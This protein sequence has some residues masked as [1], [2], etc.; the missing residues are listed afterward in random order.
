LWGGAGRP[1]FYVRAI[2]LCPGGAPRSQTELA[3]AQGRPLRRIV[4]IVAIVLAL[5]VVY[6]VGHITLIEAGREVIVLH[7]QDAGGTTVETRLWIVDDGEHAWIHGN[8]N[9]VWMRNLQVNPIVKVERGGESQ[10]YRAVPVPGPHQ[11][12]HKLLREKYGIADWWVRFISN[13]ED[14][15]PVRLARL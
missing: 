8:R 3:I 5:P 6:L 15:V 9:S 14:A 13:D 7:T 4:L 11:N 2:C 1:R 10:Q 12:I